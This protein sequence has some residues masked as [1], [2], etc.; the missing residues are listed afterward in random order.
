MPDFGEYKHNKGNSL[1]GVE[2]LLRRPSACV[3]VCVCVLCVLCVLC[4]VCV[5][6][7]GMGWWGRD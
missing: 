5:G 3:C 2:N 4:V 7:Y 6:E 1:Q